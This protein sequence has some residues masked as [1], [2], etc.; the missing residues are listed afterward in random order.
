MGFYV[1]CK[2]DIMNYFIPFISFFVSALGAAVSMPWLLR[3]CKKRGLYDMPNERKVHH[4]KI[5]RLGGVLFMP[6][7]L[8][9]VAVAMV[10]MIFLHLELPKFT[11]SSFLILTGVFLIYLIGLLDDVLGLSARVKFVIQFVAS[12]FLPLC[13]LYFNNLYGFLGIYEIPMWIGYPLTIFVCLLIV[14]SIN[15]IDG[16]DGLASGLSL[17][18]LTAFTVF[19]YQLNAMNYAMFSLGLIGAVLVFF[20]YNMFGKVENTTKTF[21]GDT[22]SLI[23]GYGLSYLAIKLAMDNDA[24]LPYRPGA[25]LMSFSLL[26]VPTFDLIRVALF[27]L[28]KGVSIF[29]ADK[30]HIHHK[31]LAAGFSMHQALVAILALQLGFCLLNGILYCNGVKDSIIV[32]LDV[33]VFTLVQI[34]LTRMKKVEE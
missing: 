12:L 15:L 33:L 4:T 26:L 22:G 29:H 25:L 19:F 2:L 31:F 21:M 16:I 10:C 13:N 11:I 23:L 18:A 5:P 1:S 6:C 32:L 14:N 27:R 17:I 24:V 3:F 28:K 20:Y 34:G 9:G 8:I 30:T 7:A